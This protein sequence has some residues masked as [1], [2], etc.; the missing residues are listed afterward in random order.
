[1]RAAE[2]GAWARRNARNIIIAAAVVLA[3]LLVFFFVRWQGQQKAD[4]AAADRG[5]SVRGRRSSASD[6]PLDPIRNREAPRCGRA[7]PFQGRAA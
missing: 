4:R 6:G 2:L 5:R 3:A 7:K 1:M